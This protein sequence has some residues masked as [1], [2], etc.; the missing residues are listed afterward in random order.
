MTS[1][2][3]PNLQQNWQYI[4]I[5]F[6]KLIGLL[7]KQI[8]L[9]GNKD[10]PSLRCPCVTE[11][12]KKR[13]QQQMH[14]MPLL[15][16]MGSGVMLNQNGPSRP[17]VATITP[18]LNR[19]IPEGARLENSNATTNAARSLQIDANAPASLLDRCRALVQEYPWLQKEI[20]D[21]AIE[22]EAALDVRLGA[23]LTWVTQTYSLLRTLLV[24]SP[25]LESDLR[26]IES[27]SGLFK[28]LA[29]MIL[30]NVALFREL[31]T[32]YRR[33][34]LVE[35][36]RN[37]GSGQISDEIS[38]VQRRSPNAVWNIDPNSPNNNG[39]MSAQSSNVNSQ[40]EVAPDLGAFR[41]C[42]GILMGEDDTSARPSQL[43]DSPI[44]SR[45]EQP[46]PSPRPQPQQSIRERQLQLEQGLQEAQQPLQQP[47]QSPQPRQSRR[48]QPQQ[49]SPEAQL[50]AQQVLIGEQQPVAPRTNRSSNQNRVADRAEELARISQGRTSLQQDLLPQIPLLSVQAPTPRSALRRPSPGLSPIVPANPNTPI[51]PGNIDLPSS[52][53]RNS[54]PQNPNDR[55]NAFEARTPTTRNPVG[56]P[57]PQNEAE[58]I[59]RTP[60][61]A[62][63]NAAETSDPQPSIR[64]VSEARARSR[65]QGR[66][67]SQLR[68]GPAPRDETEANLQPPDPPA[69]LIPIELMVEDRVVLPNGF[70]TNT[71]H[72][73]FNPDEPFNM[74]IINEML[75][76]F[77]QYRIRA[78]QDVG[79]DRI[80]DGVLTNHMLRLEKFLLE[81][82]ANR[83]ILGICLLYVVL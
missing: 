44:H 10:D 83:D 27:A 41:P 63:N 52:T 15:Q 17:W 23:Y 39:S 46:V 35:R 50:N 56:N 76:T 64:N 45:L 12:L 5:A 36:N 13:S 40:R 20:D 75:A 66:D 62:P 18:H 16:Q 34:K 25:P 14:G 71:V 72:P 6:E 7:N 8:R 37:V 29:S 26:E 57:V 58:A 51:Q 11:M 21:I 78:V 68:D 30:K 31:M 32:E 2:E 77:M 3:D 81:R 67:S 53:P 4:G 33:R 69:G 65:E 42:R 1:N 28:Q 74:D 79:I 49:E 24:D 19:R 80:T 54:T 73:N 60:N 59:L 48:P 82:I 43:L 55:L 61:N 38:M 47:A 9:Q 22:A 70:F